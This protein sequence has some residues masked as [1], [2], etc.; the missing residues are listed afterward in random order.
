MDQSNPGSWV[1]RSNVLSNGRQ[2]RR[3]RLARHGAGEDAGG[4]V[5]EQ[6]VCVFVNNIQIV[7]RGRSIDWQ[8]RSFGNMNH[9][10]GGKRLIQP[11]SGHFIYQYS[12]GR[13][14]PPKRLL[15]GAW[16]ASAEEIGQS[17]HSGSS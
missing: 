7:R 11:A 14:H 8:G 9:G 4:F 15:L 6:N 2:Q 16:V 10:V 13:D 5:H 3:A 12:P 1:G 17:L